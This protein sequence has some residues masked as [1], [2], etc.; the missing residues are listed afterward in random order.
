MKV[1]SQKSKVESQKL[2]RAALVVAVAAHAAIRSLAQCHVDPVS[3]ERV[4]AIIP[5]SESGALALDFR[6]GES[7]TRLSARD[8]SA[9]CRIT[10]ADGS[11][12]SG[13]LVRRSNS[14]G[15]VLTCAHLFDNAA[16]RIIV[17]FAN[18]Q[19]FAARLLER[20]RAHDLAVLLIR[21]PDAEPIAV[22]DEAPSGLLS[23]C[24]YGPDGQLRCFR[25]N[26]TGE[27]TAAGALYPSL[28]I[29]GAARPGDSGGGVL[30]TAGQLVELVRCASRWIPEQ[31]GRRP[32]SKD[33]IAVALGVNASAIRG[34]K[35]FAAAVRG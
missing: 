18:G 9:H 21:R 6:H 2:L 32:R 23:A 8:S 22:S 10:V 27:A 35:D 12:G 34:A 14:L 33:Q 30:N 5:E 29:A 4:C 7:S 13:T 1:K 16:G 24:G 11:A 15:L 25:G 31:L 17:T 26:V 19:R 28:A 20:D 3:G